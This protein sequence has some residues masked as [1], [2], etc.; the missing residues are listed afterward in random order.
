MKPLDIVTAKVSNEGWPISQAVLAS[1]ARKRITSGRDM[2]FAF[3]PVVFTVSRDP[4]DPQ[5][6]LYSDGA[7]TGL[8][9]ACAGFRK[10]VWRR[11]GHTRLLFMTSD[12]RIG[13]LVERF[14]GKPVRKTASGHT[15][16]FVERP[17]S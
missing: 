5:V 10:Q 11:T 1:M 17:T 8:L 6:H 2:L 12:A 13:R 9:S 3:G 7:G 4:N 15:V 16:F 14:G